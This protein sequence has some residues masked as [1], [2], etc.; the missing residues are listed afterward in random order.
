[1]LYSLFFHLKEGHTNMREF[2][3]LLE[4]PYEK[5]FNLDFLQ[6]K[7]DYDIA[8]LVVMCMKDTEII[9][10]ITIE[11]YGI[12]ENYDEIDINEHKININFKR[13]NPYDVKVPKYKYMMDSYYALMWFN[14]RIETNI[15]SKYIT[16]YILIPKKTDDGYFILNSKKAKAIW[17]M[18]EASVYTQRGKTTL[19][20]RMPII[21]YRTVTKEFTDTE[22]N[23]YSFRPYSYA[24][25]TT[26]KRKGAA[27]AKN[28]TKTRNKFINPYIIF[29]AKMGLRGAIKFLAIERM[30]TI[31]QE[32]EPE[33]HDQYIYIPFNNLFIRASKE[34]LDNDLMVS[35]IGM[36]TQVTT[37]E[38][39]VTWDILDDTAYWTSRIGIVGTKHDKPLPDFYNKGITTIMMI[40]RL[41]D[42]MTIR[43][44]RLPEAHK[45]NIYEILRWMI[46]QFDELKV[47]EN[48]DLDNKR[49]RKAEYIVKATLGRKINDNINRVITHR[50]DS[51]ANTIDTLLEIFNFGDDIILNGMRNINDLIKMD[52]ITNDLTILED[53]AYSSK[54]PEALG[55]GSSKNVMVKMRDVHPSFMGKVDCEC[56]SNSDVGMSGGSFVPYVKT[57]DGFY[58]TPEREP[59]SKMFDINVDFKDL[60]DEKDVTIIN[61][62]TGEVIDMPKLDITSYDAFNESLKARDDAFGLEYEKITII[63]HESGEKKKENKKQ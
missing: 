20:A 5:D 6:S 2:I 11:S 58:F 12:N 42:N 1:M 35:L 7:N 50:S 54:G 15:S 43:N 63:E 48:I 44:L 62:S 8:D 24:M 26:S 3:H 13:K 51:R 37:E 27:K 49:V 17:Q 39:P 52:D 40:E 9:S 25:D 31:V 32:D 10:N 41:L 36:I 28:A 21:I 61:F 47:K 56:T 4:N 46:M 16:K 45:R 23:T 18:L 57:Y 34:C 22:G 29:A 19:K 55:D 33:Y 38:F 53:L 60:A 14:I 30:V 59:Q